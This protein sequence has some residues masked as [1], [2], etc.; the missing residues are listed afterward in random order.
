ME[1]EIMIPYFKMNGKY[2]IGVV[3]ED[4]FGNS[5]KYTTK[6]EY[7][8][9]AVERKK[10]SKSVFFKTIGGDDYYLLKIK[11]NQVISGEYSFVLKKDKKILFLDLERQ[12]SDISELS[13]FTIE[14]QLYFRNNS[15]R[16]KF[17]NFFKNFFVVKKL[18]KS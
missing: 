8:I 7:L 6:D 10:S 12:M 13:I 11:K 3:N 1:K 4:N 16:V 15:I 5:E 9:C 18:Q 2:F 17:Y 14:L